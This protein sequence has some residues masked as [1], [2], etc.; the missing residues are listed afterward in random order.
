MDVLTGPWIISCDKCG[1]EQSIQL[2]L[3]AIEGMFIRGKVS[4]ECVQID[5]KDFFGE[6]PYQR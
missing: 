5:C 1:T 3:A 2:T 4:V 6:A